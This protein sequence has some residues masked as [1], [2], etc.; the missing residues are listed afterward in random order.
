MAQRVALVVHDEPLMPH[1]EILLGTTE[2]HFWVGMPV[3]DVLMSLRDVL[4]AP[5]RDAVARLWADDDA[6][7]QVV[8]IGPGLIRVTDTSAPA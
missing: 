2:V 6:L 7:R 3:Q 4:D 1:V 8:R 5:A